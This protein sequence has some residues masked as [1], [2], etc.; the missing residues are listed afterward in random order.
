MVYYHWLVVKAHSKA[1]DVPSVVA[2]LKFDELQVVL[3]GL[4]VYS[5]GLFCIT[6]CF[7]ISPHCSL[8]Y[9]AKEICFCDN[10]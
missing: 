7:W 9:N 10:N 6:L 3:N 5:D 2:I 8:T 4:T 1:Q